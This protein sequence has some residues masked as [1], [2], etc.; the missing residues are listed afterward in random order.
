VIFEKQS[1]KQEDQRSD[2]STSPLLYVIL[3]MMSAGLEFR[4]SPLLYVIIMMMSAALES[5]ILRS[6]SIAGVESYTNWISCIISS[7]VL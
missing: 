2:E 6:W 7:P 1:R 4:T 5:P 3:M